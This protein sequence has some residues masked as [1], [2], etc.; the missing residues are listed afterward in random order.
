MDSTS[1]G[2]LETPYMATVRRVLHIYYDNPLQ[3]E[4]SARVLFWVKIV[5]DGY[6][7]DQTNMT[8]LLEYLLPFVSVGHSF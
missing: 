6:Y 8:T 4:D 5:N 3:D 7:G 2:I 1:K